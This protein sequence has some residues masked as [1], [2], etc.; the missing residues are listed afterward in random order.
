[1]FAIVRIFRRRMQGRLAEIDRLT[2]D[3][4]RIARATLRQARRVAHNLR[5]TLRHRP[6][7]VVRRLLADLDATVSLT[8]R[9]QR[10]PPP[11]GPHGV[12][13]QTHSPL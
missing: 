9:R 4:A 6:D 5:R 2:A 13:P 12:S 10:P 1:M 3:A 7:G 8:D 11:A